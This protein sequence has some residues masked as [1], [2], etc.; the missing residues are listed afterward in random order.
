MTTN[1]K[2]IT[3]QT[4]GNNQ[5]IARCFNHYSYSEQDKEYIRRDLDTV[6]E[7]LKAV[8]SAIPFGCK[9]KMLKF[10]NAIMDAMEQVTNAQIALN[11]M[12]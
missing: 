11:E 9:G 7:G 3:T 12:T 6:K 2:K 10:A 8:K 5:V 1:R 4:T